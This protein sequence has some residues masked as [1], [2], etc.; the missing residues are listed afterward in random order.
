MTPESEPIRLHQVFRLE[1]G[2]ITA[3]VGAGGKT[4]TCFRLA[5][6]FQKN[7]IITT[8]TRVGLNQYDG[9]ARHFI[10]HTKP[11]LDEALTHAGEIPLL[12]TCETRDGDT[13]RGPK[14]EILAYLLEIWQQR[15]FTLLIEADGA[16]SLPLKAPADH[17]P[18]IPPE[19]QTV[20][21][22]AGCAGIGSPIN[23]NTVHRPDSYVRLSGLKMGDTITPQAAL[24]VLTHPQGG[25]KNIPTRAKK[26][27]LL[28]Q[29]ETPEIQATAGEIAKQAINL[30]FDRAIIASLDSI[31]PLP[32]VFVRFEP[33]VGAVVL[34]GDQ[35]RYHSVDETIEQIEICQKRLEDAGC[36]SFQVIDPETNSEFTQKLKT[37]KI[38]RV[39][40]PDWQLGKSTG[41]HQLMRKL[42][43]RAGALILFDLG[44]VLP[45]GQLI[46]AILN[47]W[48]SRFASVVRPLIAG[49]R[50]SPI[51]YDQSVF[52][53]FANLQG[54]QG[55][56]SLTNIG[57][58]EYLPWHDETG[59]NRYGDGE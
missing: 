24:R 5:Q 37:L 27:L 23:E 32:I 20:I 18:C 36:Q 26:I 19:S 25:F 2:S 3:V 57:K 4:S 59:Q 45:S 10:V 29:A 30:G 16:R 46:Q 14:P 9:C 21:V 48:Q 17:E 22:V 47:A 55:I 49:R 53:K 28:N 38:S 35:L 15:K 34:D 42:T 56:N 41:Y 8:T 51:L 7:V 11:E 6:S 31:R 12:L 1:E 39:T 13:Y 43:T 58:I 33:V 52:P 40:N 54:D 50:A 44:Q